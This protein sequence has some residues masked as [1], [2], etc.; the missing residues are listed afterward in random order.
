MRLA[1]CLNV[2]N[3]GMHQTVGDSVKNVAIIGGG[4]AGFFCA[5]NL[6]RL[7][8]SL[9]V[10][11]FEKNN[12][13]LSKVKVSG[14]GRCNVTHA[15][16]DIQ[17]M[18]NRYPR[19]SNFVKKL[20]HHFFTKD[21]IT[22]FE[23][24]GVQLKAEQDGRMFPVTNS[25]QTIINCLLKE[26]DKYGV[27]IK[28]QHDVKEINHTNKMLQLHFASGQI[29][30]ANAVCIA[31]GG[32]PKLSMFDFLKNIHHTIVAPVPSLFTF[33]MPRHAITK[34][35]GV[36]IADAHVK[37]VG[38]KLQQ[39]GPVL[40]THWGLSGPCILRL[41]AFAAQHLAEKNWQFQVLINWLPT[42]NEQQLKNE[43]QQLRFQIAAQ[44]IYHKNPFGLPQ[45]FWEYILHQSQISPNL[46]WADVSAKSQNLLI[47]NIIQYECEIS[48]KTTFKEEFVTAGGIDLSEIDVNTMMSK[49]VSGLFFS[50]EIINVDGITGG[51]NFQNAWSTGWVAAN[52]IADYLG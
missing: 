51:Y 41:S 15:C 2:F 31:S 29:F 26:A 25:S 37:I 17:E 45:R 36:S 5:V 50:G 6:A 18:A 46:R 39:R 23:K 20:F 12:K 21:T 40:I 22:W 9:R 44:N 49:K 27:E 11:I 3:T 1:N 13:L 47:K 28:M 14:G 19:G 4:A 8:P 32:F 7:N 10:T 52:G 34:L 30:Y 42:Y 33:N 24:R 35:M 38:T 43:M 16:F 48:G